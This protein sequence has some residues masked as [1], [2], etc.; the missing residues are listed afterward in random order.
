[1]EDNILKDPLIVTV[2]TQYHILK[3][4][5]LFGDQSVEAVMKKLNQLHEMMFMEPKNSETM[6]REENKAALKYLMLLKQNRR[7]KIKRRGYADG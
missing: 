7:G 2:I 4:I 1:M 3:G 6:S 5:K